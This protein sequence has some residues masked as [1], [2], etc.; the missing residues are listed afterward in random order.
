MTAA[1]YIF[2]HLAKT[3]S[4][5]FFKKKEEINVFYNA[6]INSVTTLKLSLETITPMISKSNSAH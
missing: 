1:G 3:G 6:L 2:F 4:N 5:F